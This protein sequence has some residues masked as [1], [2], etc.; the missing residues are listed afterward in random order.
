MDELVRKHVEIVCE[1]KPMKKYPD[2][3][4]LTSCILF[5]ASSAAADA[6]TY[7]VRQGGG[8]DCSGVQECLNRLQPG[9]TLLVH[10]GTYAEGNLNLIPSGTSGAPVTI[11]AA[12]GERAVIKP[13]PGTDGIH[14]T[15]YAGTDVAFIVIDGLVFDCSAVE[16]NCIKFESYETQ[17]HDVIFQ[18]NE[19]FGNPRNNGILGG[20]ERIKILN[21]DVHDNGLIPQDSTGLWCGYGMYIAGVDM[22]IAGNRVHHNG[23]WGIHHYTS[24]GGAR[25]DVIAG[26]YVYNNGLACSRSD[27]IILAGG[28]NT[29]AYNN[30][31]FNNLHTGIAV[32]Y[33]SNSKVFNNTV[34]NNGGFGIEYGEGSNAEIVNNISFNNDGGD[35]VDAGGLRGTLVRS[36]N[37]TSDP[38]FV[39][40]SA[41]DFR[42]TAGSSAIDAGVQI[43]GVTDGFLGS[44]PDIG[45][46]EYGD[47]DC[48]RWGG[49][50]APPS[51]S[52]P[53]LLPAGSAGLRT[54]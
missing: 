47:S 25:N 32:V 26:N 54:M 16:T 13:P 52:S 3:F 34:F 22:L 17:I 9:D 21:N 19:V 10:A 20:G 14:L 51:G 53:R 37:L 35:I 49:G 30:V 1:N 45:A 12:L 28:D 4:I 39:N 29:Q 18:N 31:V 2:L 6:A 24:G 50:N 15:G 27:G 42:L 11:A 33:G 23:G 43:P 40:A 48:P 36:N 7:H 38:N 41:S 44:A 8:G 5:L 46:C